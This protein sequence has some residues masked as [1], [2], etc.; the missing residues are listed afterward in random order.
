M[1]A[2]W[3]PEAFLEEIRSKHELNL[4]LSQ[5]VYDSSRVSTSYSFKNELNLRTSQAVYE[6]FSQEWTH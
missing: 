3:F 1:F 6:V 5:A 2:S 4:R